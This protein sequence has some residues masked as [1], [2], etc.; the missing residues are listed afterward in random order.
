M[1]DQKV[2][3]TW[4]YVL[5]NQVEEDIG[6]AILTLMRSFEMISFSDEEDVPVTAEDD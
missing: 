1:N 4:S 6:V 5:V 2:V 3:E